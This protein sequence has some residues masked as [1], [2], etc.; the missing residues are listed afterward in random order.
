[1][2]EKRIDRIE[3]RLA[4]ALKTIDELS[5]ETARHGQIIARLEAQVALLIEREA[6]RETEALGGVIV[7][8]ERPPHY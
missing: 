8:D 5:E 2:D 6:A 3:E 4:D 7:G 1:M